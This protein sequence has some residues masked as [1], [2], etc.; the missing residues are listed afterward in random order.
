MDTWM[1]VVTVETHKMQQLQK[2]DEQTENIIYGAYA[3]MKRERGREREKERKRE[4]EREREGIGT[5]VSERKIR[6][7]DTRKSVDDRE[8]ERD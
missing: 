4:R 2:V 3:Q 7:M 5:P 6:N 1:G 8:R